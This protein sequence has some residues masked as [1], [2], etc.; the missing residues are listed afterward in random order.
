M[1]P[2]K[3]FLD[4]SQCFWFVSNQINYLHPTTLAWRS[5]SAV[6]P[7]YVLEVAHSQY[8][9]Q[10]FVWWKWMNTFIMQISSDSVC[11]V[12]IRKNATSFILCY[13]KYE[14]SF[15]VN[16]RSRKH[17]CVH[18]DKSNVNA[19]KRQKK[20]GHPFI[21]IFSVCYSRHKRREHISIIL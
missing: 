13:G 8:F 7:L 6:A 18:D 16:R 12:W 20:T 4:S 5:I 14:C 3:P 10:C 17:V 9:P 21:T 2:C 19:N 11:L 1:L 15:Q